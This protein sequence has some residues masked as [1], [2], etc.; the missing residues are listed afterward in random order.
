MAENNQ[1]LRTFTWD[2]VPTY[3]GL[4]NESRGA[5]TQRSTAEAEEYLRQPNLSPLRDCVIAEADGVS[6]GFALTVPEI[7]VRRTIVEGTVHPDYRRTGLGRKLLDNAVEH[8]RALK[9][10]LVHVSASPDDAHLVRLLES[11]GFTE[12]NR[13]WQMRLLV[14]DLVPGKPASGYEVRQLAEG[15]A[16]V[17]ARI[18]NLAFTGSWG[19]AP[20]TP[21]ELDYRLH[22]T[23]AGYHDVLLLTVEGQPAAYCW[24]RMQRVGDERRG[25]IW[26]IG[27]DSALRGKGLGRAM[28][29]EGLS[30]MLTRGA[31]AFELTVYADNTPAVKLYE[32]VGFTWKHDIVWYELEL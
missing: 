25:I 8:S 21:Q 23:G 7:L 27:A 15:E 31:T 20:N 29:L 16:N 2:D 12:R 14:D 9:A 32:S 1:T 24:T 6:V 30:L 28:L 26:M 5:E 3:A 11:S 19:F 18:Q 4:L 10:D 22:M 13:Q 17:F